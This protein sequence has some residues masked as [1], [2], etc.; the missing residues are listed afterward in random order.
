MGIR[1]HTRI[2]LVFT[3]ALVTLVLVL[4]TMFWGYQTARHT[5]AL[6]TE[7]HRPASDASRL[8]IAEA[9]RMFTAALLYPLD[10]V[11]RTQ[12]E[13]RF[14]SHRAGFQHWLGELGRY[15][16]TPEEA[17]LLER[18]IVH[19][20]AFMASQNRIK[21]LVEQGKVAKARELQFT[22]EGPEVAEVMAAADEL[23]TLNRRRVEELNAL[24][25]RRFDLAEGISIGITLV[26]LMVA[27][28]LWWITSRD[29]VAPL[30]SLMAGGEAI[31]HGRFVRVHHPH[32]PRTLELKALEDTFNAMSERVEAANTTLERQVEARTHELAEANAKLEALVSELKTLDT[33]KSNFLSVT[34]HELL[35][36]INFITG[37]GSALE[38][39]LLGPLNPQQ[40]EAVCKLLQ[41]AERLTRM[42]R[43]TLEYNQV[44]SGTLEVHPEAVAV[45]EA[46]VDAVEMLE[47]AIAARD[48]H[49]ETQWPEDLPA[50]EADPDRL[51][52]VLYELL[53]NAIKFSPEGTT[54]VVA[55][56]SGPETV[57][58][59]VR[60]Q[61]QGIPEEA[62]KDLFR[63]FYQADFT[64]TRA[65]GG[66]GLG[67]AIARHLVLRMNGELAVDST[68][69]VGTTVRVVLPRAK[70][71]A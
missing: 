60:D 41:G 11:N 29:I 50:V 28:V 32:A 47:A 43:N 67:L 4:M 10:E 68:V 25:L 56:A 54:V 37:F 61:G 23:F 15:A 49:V 64:L 39:E 48:V 52:Q 17:V 66:L 1:L 19:D 6:I 13:A 26:G 59:S 36:P 45:P 44:L 53:D 70:A 40:H 9:G 24:S 35:T 33:M 27:A 30:R 31:A 46:V 20:K 58:L 69:G 5:H 14:N 8:L 18:I 57:S 34:S 22:E 65:H 21:A 71:L 42:V 38:D 62:L 2:G 16:E 12:I 7:T 55:A 51:R 63:P 3:T